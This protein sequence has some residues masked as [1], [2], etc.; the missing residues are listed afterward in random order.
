M[1]WAFP[2]IDRIHEYTVRSQRMASAESTPLTEKKA[3]GSVPETTEYEGE[4]GG[5]FVVG[6]CKL[7]LA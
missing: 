3:Y 2:L 4:D 7:T 6:R 5:A 1:V